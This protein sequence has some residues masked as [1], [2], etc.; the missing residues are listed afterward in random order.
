MKMFLPIRTFVGAVFSGLRNPKL[1][2]LLIRNGL[3]P[4]SPKIRKIREENE[5]FL[6][7]MLIFEPP[8]NK[9]SH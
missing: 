4:W 8:K 2:W 6:V 3:S 7:N 5:D 1:C 9:R